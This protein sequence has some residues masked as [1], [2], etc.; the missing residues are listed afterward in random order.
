MIKMS[1]HTDLCA[2]L[3][4]NNYFINEISVILDKHRNKYYYVHNN[5]KKHKKFSLWHSSEFLGIAQLFPHTEWPHLLKC[6]TSVAFHQVHSTIEL[7][8]GLE[9]TFTL[10]SHHATTVCFIVRPWSWTHF[11]SRCQ[12]RKHGNRQVVYLKL[13]H[14]LSHFP[15][16]FKAQFYSNSKQDCG[17][18]KT[19]YLVY[20]KSTLR[21]IT[22]RLLS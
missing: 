13:G 16:I 17:M 15:K 21:Y 22:F 3:A 9:K 18:Q 2:V 10:V 5:D 7:P 8:W 4:G 12:K 6:I 20:D 19:D 11:E 1:S 14:Q